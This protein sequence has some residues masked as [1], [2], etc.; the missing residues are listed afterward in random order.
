MMLRADGAILFGE[1]KE[2]VIRHP[3]GE[4]HRVALPSAATFIYEISDR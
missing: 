1:G 4:E 2:L 3:S